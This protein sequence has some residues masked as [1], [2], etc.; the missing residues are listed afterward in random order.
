[1]LLIDT[2]LAF[3][4]E[5]IF[6]AG[7]SL[8]HF[9]N[10]LN[11]PNNTYIAKTVDVDEDGRIWIMVSFPWNYQHFP[12]NLFA[13]NMSYYSK[14]EDFYLDIKG[15]A[16]VAKDETI[17]RAK[18]NRISHDS[19]FT[20]DK[21]LLLSF[22]IISA[23]YMQTSSAYSRFCQKYIH[24]ISKWWITSHYNNQKKAMP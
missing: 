8:I 7:N 10:N 21:L 14:Q 1:M 9:S 5:K 12:N 11:I 6:R 13:A 20:G 2:N 19:S 24:N 17:I 3:I 23:N 4:R 22:K 15:I 18:L 16:R